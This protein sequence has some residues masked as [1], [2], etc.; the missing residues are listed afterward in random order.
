MSVVPEFH[1][2]ARLYTNAVEQH[3]SKSLSRKTYV[4]H[5][6]SCKGV[7]KNKICLA[8]LKL[9]SCATLLTLG[10]LKTGFEVIRGGLSDM[11]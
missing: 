9:Y 2:G 11:G 8:L 5:H 6:Q 3:V 10:H 7:L 4:K 1:L